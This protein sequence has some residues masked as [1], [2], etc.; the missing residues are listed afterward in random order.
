MHVYSSFSVQIY[1][2]YIVRGF[3]LRH[4]CCE[5]IL[6]KDK[7]YS[8]DKLLQNKA[9]RDCFIHDLLV[10]TRFFF[11]FIFFFFLCQ[12]ISRICA[13]T[14]LGTRVFL[15]TF[16]TRQIFFFNYSDARF[17]FYISYRP[18]LATSF[19]FFFLKAGKELIIFSL[20]HFM[21]TY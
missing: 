17:I 19:F 6:T 3:L 10:D 15:Q 4:L 12:D 5:N 8:L 9:N 2:Q 7:L 13:S 11:V 18:F 14:F 1:M 21:F 16:R 20:F